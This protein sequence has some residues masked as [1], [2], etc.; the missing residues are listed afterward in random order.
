MY[1][2]A[3]AAGALQLA[4]QSQPDRGIKA[5]FFWAIIIVV[6]ALLIFGIQRASRGYVRR[7]AGRKGQGR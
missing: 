3:A 4:A 7:A 6:V 1:Y 5:A 2:Q